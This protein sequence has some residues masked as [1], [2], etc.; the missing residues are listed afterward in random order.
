[1]SLSSILVRFLITCSLIDVLVSRISPFIHL[2]LR[3]SI[4]QWAFTQASNGEEALEKTRSNEY[5]LIII[6][7]HM[8]EAH[9]KLLGH[10]V[11]RI[12]RDKG[13][14]STIVGCSGNDVKELHLRAGTSLIWSKPI[15]SDNEIVAQ[16]APLL[17]DR[18]LKI[19]L[20]DDSTIGRRSLLRRLKNTIPSK[21]LFVEASSGEEAI[22]RVRD[23]SFDV[24]VLDEH[25]GPGMAGETKCE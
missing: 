2:K 18:D 22:D 20:V 11:V 13:I 3:A 4:Q 23:T 12:M 7:Q 14:N 21:V 15:P 5:D 8:A 25:M 24:I 17:F 16:L 1:M 10:E 6:D 9:G 19:L